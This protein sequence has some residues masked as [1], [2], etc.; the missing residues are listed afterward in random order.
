MIRAGL[1]ALL[2]ASPAG[3]E[4]FCATAW[5]KVAAGLTALG[6]VSGSVAQDGD[7]C[8]VQ[9][10]VLD[11][12]GPYLPDWHVDRLR[13]R[14]AA[15]GWL[16]DGTGAPDGLE[17]G[18]EGLRLVVQTGDAQMDW[19]LAAQARPNAIRAEASLAW[20]AAARETFRARTWWSFRLSWPGW[21]CPRPG[22]CRCR[23]QVL[24]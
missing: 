5:E 12:D 17:I 13:F 4:S 7:W 14:G 10:A 20:D 18:V 8:V 23:P 11:L 24:R 15:L 1:F 22:R 9:G 16:V 6:T 2:L 21:T 3:A 19:L